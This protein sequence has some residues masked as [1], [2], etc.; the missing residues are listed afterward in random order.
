MTHSLTT[1]PSGAGLGD[2]QL[3]AV[4][5]LDRLDDGALV[6]APSP[7]ARRSALE[8]HQQ[9]ILQDRDGPFALLLGRDE[10]VADVA[11]A[12]RA[13]VRAG[14][15]EHASLEEAR[16]H[17]PRTSRRAA[18]RSR[19]TSS[20]ARRRRGGPCGRA[21]RGGGPAC[22][23]TPRACAR[24]APRRP[25][26]RPRRAGR[27]P[28]ARSR[29]SGGNGEGRRSAPDRR[30]RSRCGSRSSKTASTAC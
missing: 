18:P 10:R 2:A 22:A 24:R 30:R 25:R 27:T 4:E 9:R 17:A 3:A 1:H 29:R 28:A 5:E 26:R 20:P 6:D 12:R 21:R 16:R 11:F 7:R 23:R 13:E 19:D 8:T 14:G 15:D